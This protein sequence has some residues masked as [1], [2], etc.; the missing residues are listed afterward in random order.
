MEL[1]NGVSKAVQTVN[2]GIAGASQIAR[3]WVANAIKA[4]K[5][6]ALVSLLSRDRARGES[7]AADFSISKVETDLQRFVNDPSITAIYVSTSNDRHAETVVAAAKA[8]KHVLCEKPLS[9]SL[10]EAVRMAETCDQAGVILGTNHH[11]RTSATHGAIRRLVQEGKVGKVLAARVMYCEYLP[12]ELQTWRTSD[13][14]TG[15]VIYDLTTHN[16]D[17]LRFVLGLEPLEAMSMKAASLIGRN[18]VEDQTQSIVRFAG[19]VLAYLHESYAFAHHETALEV[20]GSEGAIYGRGIM[21]EAPVGHVYIRRG[22]HMEEVP[23][24]HANLYEGAI[25]KFNAAVL[26][27]GQPAATGWDGVRSLAAALSVKQSAESGK[28]VSIPQF[29]ADAASKRRV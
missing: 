11:M 5:S 24:E 17:I 27:G 10:Q 16:I 7:F 18:G 25:A 4:N 26:N 28:A 15:G 23:V 3:S 2:W 1:A 9:L 19:E 14:A 20:H 13:L 22:K 8:G 12:E 21:D 29:P 6:G